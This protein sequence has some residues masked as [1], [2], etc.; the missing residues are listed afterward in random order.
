MRYEAAR[1]KYRNRPTDGYDSRAEAKRARELRALE[2]NGAISDLQ[3]Q[4]VFELIPAQYAIVDGKRRCVERAVTYTADFVYRNGAGELVVE[5]VKSPVSRTQQYV[6]R[7]K[8]MLHVHG[9]P[10]RELR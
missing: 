6:I 10:I 2:W 5:D 4:V 3:E 9:V 1:R 7:R 8:L